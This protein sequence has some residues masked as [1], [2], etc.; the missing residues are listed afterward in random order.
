[1]IYKVVSVWN[2]WWMGGGD[3]ILPS[4][5]WDRCAAEFGFKVKQETSAAQTHYLYDKVKKQYLSDNNHSWPLLNDTQDFWRCVNRTVWKYELWRVKAEIK[6][7]K[8]F[9]YS[10]MFKVLLVQESTT[11]HF[12]IPHEQ[13]CYFIY[14]TYTSALNGIKKKITAVYCVSTT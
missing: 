10:W 11:V 1:M 14:K 3:L 7:K 12:T 8:H 9:T 5:Q 4:S 2:Y 13:E 6:K